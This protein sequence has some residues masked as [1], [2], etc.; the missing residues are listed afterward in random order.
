MR[1]KLHDVGFQTK[2]K[3]RQQQTKK[4]V[5]GL[6][7]FSIKNR[8]VKEST[9]YLNQSEYGNNNPNGDNNNKNDDNK[10]KESNV[11]NFVHVDPGLLV[12]DTIA[13]V[14]A[15]QLIGLLDIINDPDFIQAGGW[16]QPLPTMPT[17]LNELVQRM[18]TLCFT[19]ILSTVFI[20]K[21]ISKNDSSYKPSKQPQLF[22]TKL[23]WFTLTLFTILR[24]AIGL[25]GLSTT[26]EATT[27]VI[28]IESL[29]D[30]YFVGLFTLSLRFIYNKYF[31][32]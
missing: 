26:G 15:S 32:Y 3:R 24:V 23:E 25:V 8:I 1:K 4:N 12:T 6:K 2:I 13:I 30:C 16:F 18:A 7:N 17:T 28:I 11:D 5:W 19:W 10:L 22:W 9:L 27:D 20:V 31:L 14:L 21:T 29:R